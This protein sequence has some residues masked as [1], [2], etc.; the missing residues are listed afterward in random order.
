[1]N[2][3]MAYNSNDRM[4]MKMASNSVGHFVRKLDLNKRKR[5]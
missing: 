5:M 4:N 2:M 1:M 3:E